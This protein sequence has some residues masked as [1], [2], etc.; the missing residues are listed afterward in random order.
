MEG[1][2]VDEASDDETPIDD[3]LATV[4]SSVILLDA[5]D[6]GLVDGLALAAS[7]VA[8]AEGFAEVVVSVLVDGADE[9]AAVV[10]L[11][12]A[13][14]VLSAAV[15]VSAVSVAVVGTVG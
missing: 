13:A 6:V 10:P 9:L 1:T 2:A 7:E 5:S 12:A 8:A 11:D 15:E 4:G 3:E 14:N